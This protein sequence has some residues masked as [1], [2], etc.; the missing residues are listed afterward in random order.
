MRA[1]VVRDQAIEFIDVPTPDPGPGEIRVRVAAAGVNPVDIQTVDGVYR[2]LGWITQPDHVGLGWD[3]A[4]IVTAAAAGF[5][6]GDRVAALSAGVDKPL[7]PYAEEVVVPASAAA[8][9]PANLELTEAATVPLNSLTAAQAL[10][11]LGPAT[12]SLL[13]TGAAG[14]VGGYAIALAARAGWRVTALARQADRD[15]V[16]ANGATDLLTAPEG[17]F[18][19]VLDAAV[20]GDAAVALVRDGGHYMGV[21]P[22]R[23]PE[24]HGRITVDAVLVQSD[25]ATLAALLQ[26]T[27][28][29]TL[30]A[31]ISTTLP[32]DEAAAAH[33][34]LA[35]GGTRGR[36]LLIP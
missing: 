18:D 12:G 20:L 10:D 1:A 8:L 34:T 21:Q 6:V 30:P 22:P 32:L 15:F 28:D 9:V 27:A 2:A 14:G 4:G 23:K 33:K 31:R 26:D 25:G 24:G 19:A 3:V 16:L 17:T 35:A 29:G 36:L 7:G 5:K 13:V 11:Q